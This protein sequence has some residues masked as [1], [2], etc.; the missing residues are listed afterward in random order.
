MAGRMLIFTFAILI[1]FREVDA[2][3]LCEYQ[4]L[5]VADS[6]EWVSKNGK[7]G[8]IDC[9]AQDFH[10]YLPEDSYQC[11]SHFLPELDDFELFRQYSTNFYA[12]QGNAVAQRYLRHT[13]D[14]SYNDRSK[15]F[16]D[17]FAPIGDYTKGT[18]DM[19]GAE[20]RV[21]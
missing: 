17:T 2:E 20:W 18:N 9:G 16:K 11:Y 5:S 10:H 8:P 12:G 6:G 21:G 7:V 13:E 14:A 19:A 3:R 1:T 15:C 4:G